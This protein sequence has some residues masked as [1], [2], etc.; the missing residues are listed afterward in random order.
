[1]RARGRRSAAILVSCAILAA[2]A[3]WAGH[4]RAARAAQ[5]EAGGEPRHWGAEA[6]SATV[7]YP[8][9]AEPVGSWVYDEIDRQIAAGNLD[10]LTFTSRPLPRALIAAR[11]A[12]ALAAGKRSIG[13]SRL[14]RELAWEGRR[15][16]LRYDYEDTRPWITLG[17]QDA[18]VT[19]NGLVTL[20]GAFAE[21]SRPEIG[22]RSLVGFRGHFWNPPGV[23]LNGEFVVTEVEDAR[24]FGDPVFGD[25]DIQLWTPRFAFDWHGK[26]WEV[27]G[28]R[29]SN[30]WGPGRS[31]GLLLGGGA[32]PFGQVGYRA[33]LGTF[34]TGTAIHGWLSQA[35]GRFVAFHRVEFNLGRGLRLGVGEGVRYDGGAP[36]PL[37]LVNIAP[38][39]AVERL[40]TAEGAET[41]D[42]DSLFRSNYMPAVD[43]HWTFAPGWAVYGEL[44]VD[45][46]KTSGEGPTRLAY[47]LGG[48]RVLEGRRRLTLQAEYTRVYNYTYSVFYGRDFYHAGQPLGYP[49]GPDLADLNA[50][51]DL[52][53]DLA[54][55]VTA[56]GFLT[57]RGEGNDGRPWCYL[58]QETDN[59]FGTDCQ[60][61][62][63]A[64]GRE[65]AGVIERRA[66]FEAGA[67]YAPRDN[68][69]LEGAAGLELLADEDHVEGADATHPT[70][71][72]RAAWRW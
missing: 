41:A 58:W 30:R 8:F 59:P 24:R 17:P 20:G 44:L 14:A 54:W 25:T 40:L 21:G 72:F 39:A 68:L 42:R 66:G 12:E 63:D 61:L 2:A 65:M 15:M 69:F 64:S 26:S 22:R 48:T 43:L 4:P 13:L 7:P 1:M 3:A 62:G 28:G 56:H 6:R 45:D 60:T 46:F 5:G 10:G 34:I 49:L 19:F 35:E 32:Q 38:Y 50:W 23:S 11:V 70:A 67:R 18:L 31:G 29:E 52:D 57:R 27:W 53:L 16:G 71:W 9:V 51:A 37:Y 55:T 36:E 33:H 47:Q